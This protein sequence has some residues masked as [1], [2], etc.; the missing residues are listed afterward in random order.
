MSVVRYSAFLLRSQNYCKQTL[1]FVPSI[2]SIRRNCLTTN[3]TNSPKKCRHNKVCFFY[4]YLT[5]VLIFFY[6]FLINSIYSQYLHQIFAP[7]TQILRDGNHFAIYI[8]NTDKFVFYFLVS[9]NFDEKCSFRVRELKLIY[10]F[11]I[12]FV[13]LSHHSQLYNFYLHFDF[14]I[15]FKFYS[16]TYKKKSTYFRHIK[17]IK[18]LVNIQ[19]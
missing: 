18:K 14:N 3:L 2:L 9:D 17:Q 12:F 10:V 5:Y 11:A 8:Y 6:F 1:S 19:F 4:Y 16:Y 15:F 7:N 13:Y